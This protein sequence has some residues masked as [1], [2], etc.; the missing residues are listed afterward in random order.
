MGVFLTHPQAEGFS[1][2]VGE[3]PTSEEFVFEH[4]S[5]LEINQRNVLGPLLKWADLH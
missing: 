1:Q 3:S 2:G 5:P 4:E